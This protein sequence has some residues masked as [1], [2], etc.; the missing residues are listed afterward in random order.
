MKISELW[1]REWVDPAVDAHALAAKLNMAGIECEAEAL[2]QAP[3]TQVVVARILNTAP[4]PQ[5][6]R[7]RVCEVDAG[8]G[9]TLS[10]VCG[11]ANARP[12]I[13]VPAA[14]PGAK[15]PNGMEIKQAKLRGVDSAGMLCSASELGLAEKSEGLL[16][17]DA[18]AK[19]GTPIVDHLRLNDR[20]LNL[21]LTPNRGDC[22]GI[23]GVA[24]EVGALYG[25]GVHEPAVAVAPVTSNERVDIAIDDVHGCPHYVGRV[26]SGLRADAQ[27]PDWMRERLRRSGIRT[28]HPVVDITNY[29]MIELGQPLHAF[30]KARLSGGIRVRRARSG[31]KL[32]LL[33]EQTLDLHA[34]DLL[35]TDGSGPLVLAGIM[36]G[37]SSGVSAT[38]TSI[39]LESACFD[40]VS[41]AHSGRRYKLLS[42]SRYRNERGVDPALQRKAIERATQLVLELCGGRAGPV[43]ES[44]T[45]PKHAAEIRLRHARVTKLLGHA[46]AADEVPPL[47]TRLGIEVT[48][49]S[50]GIWHTKVPT[51]RYD[52]R[53]EADLIEEVARLYGY[54]RIPARA[55]AAPL[56][57]FIE[58]ETQRRPDAIKATLI[59]H[60]YQE[61]VTYSFVDPKLQ[62]QLDPDR[63][64]TAVALDN[65][66]AETMAVMRTSLWPG[67]LS[68]WMHNRQ[69][70]TPRAKL[71]EIGAC[72][73]LQGSGTH[74]TI[75]LSGL[76]AGAAS[77]E[78]W[79]EKSRAADFY[80]AKGDLE[81]LF[82][83]SGADWRF[84]ADRHPALH[85][86]RSARILRDGQ[87]V[88]WL[89]ALHPSLLAKLDL[90]E[91]VVLFELDA[92]AAATAA[93]PKPEAPSE[94]PSSRR[95]LAFILSDSVTVETLLATVRAAGGDLLKLARIFDVYHGAGV[96][97]GSK[98]IA[99]GLIFQSASRTLNDEEVDAAVR[100][101]TASVITQLGASF[102][103]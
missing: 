6:D 78:Q 48:T 16:E 12:G 98:S 27:T 69:R 44:G 32:T 70:Q 85:P 5:A 65:P 2:M 71:F 86:G 77:P 102:R 7:L 92:A 43:V 81:T 36:G 73:A 9:A 94:F 80:D 46:L 33:N 11:A 54:D 89:G 45:A 93:L 61:L 59:A 39:F 63:Q 19:P 55:Y 14:L 17:L 72:F 79:G 52:L 30:D 13:L 50:P 51:W 64:S 34:D 1:L 47:L 31:E 53:M 38:T 95:D 62:S 56:A 60:G 87:P 97:E 76:V 37:T 4:H 15:L 24:R 58:A 29:V 68:T 20:L 23:A 25:L 57:G 22:L 26:I 35:I 67:L 42:D 99:L 88:G 41:I 74:E 82:A 3:I 49:E 40:P 83:G 84:V 10:I 96:P 91:D 101:I 18:S 8:T 66:I 75:R 90:A 103:G 100:G 28:I 21:E